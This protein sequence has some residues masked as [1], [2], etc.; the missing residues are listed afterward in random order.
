MDLADDVFEMET[1]NGLRDEDSNMFSVPSPPAPALVER[2]APST[3]QRPTNNINNRK[4]NLMIGSLPSSLAAIRPASLPN[5]SHMRPKPKSPQSPPVPP[6]SHER[7]H[8]QPV[9]VSGPSMNGA[10]VSVRAP[11]REEAEAQDDDDEQLDPREAEILRLVAASTPSHRAAWKKDSKAWQLFVSRHGRRFGEETV[12]ILEEDEEDEEESPRVDS[13]RMNGSDDDE[14][15]ESG[16]EEER[17]INVPESRTKR[18]MSLQFFTR[19][20]TSIVNG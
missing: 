6:P 17:R 8:S 3:P 11:A 13:S 5:V 16:G 10:S 19:T 15:T 7:S 1:E 2:P 14:G 20:I 18:G 4:K 9:T 12:G